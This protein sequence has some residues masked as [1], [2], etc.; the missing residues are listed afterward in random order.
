MPWVKTKQ[1]FNHYDG[2]F[3]HMNEN[4]PP[5]TAFEESF[6]AWQRVV[7]CLEQFA[8]C[9][10]AY[11]DSLR[12]TSDPTE[13]PRRMTDRLEPDISDFIPDLDREL[14]HVALVE[15]VKLDLD[16]RCQPPLGTADVSLGS[17]AIQIERLE[18]EQYLKR[19]PQLLTNGRPPADL[20]YEA[21]HVR[22]AT[23]DPLTIEQIKS[24]FP[25]QSEAL[26]RLLALEQG[27]QSTSL[28]K[29]R[30]PP[31]FNAGEQVDDFDLLTQLGSGAFATVY[32]A[33]Q[34]SL[35]RL[36]ALKISADQGNEP[37][38]LAQL[39]HPHI[40]RVY[41]QRICQDRG[42]RLLYMQY[43]S[44]GTLKAAIDFVRS[45]DRCQLDGASLVRAVDIQLDQ[46]GQSVPAESANR[47]F[48][49]QASWEQTICRL[50][51]QLAGALQYAHQQGVL[52]R[53]L[54]PANVLLTAEAG[55]QLVDFNISFCS[56]IDGA[57]PT[58]YFGGS[59][60]YMSPEQLAACDPAKG[61][62]PQSLGPS[63]D[64]FSLGV[65]LWETYFGQRPFADQNLQGSW[66][67]TL[68][69][70]IEQRKNGPVKIE[71]DRLVSP[72][73]RALHKVLL[74]CLAFDPQQRIQTGE[75]LQHELQ[76]CAQPGAKLILRPQGN[77]WIR[78]MQRHPLITLV[79]LAMVPNIGATLFNIYFNGQFVVPGLSS[80]EISA[81]TVQAKFTTIYQF[82][83]VIIYFLAF[84]FIVWRSLPL[85]RATKSPELFFATGSSPAE[86]DRLRRKSLKLGSFIATVC[87]VFWASA[88]FVYP[89]ALQLWG[90]PTWPRGYLHFVSAHVLSGMIAG[91]YPF[92]GISWFAIRG[93]YPQLSVQPGIDLKG[94]QAE[95]AELSRRSWFWMACAMLLPLFA[96][97]LMVVF[98]QASQVPLAIL[99][100][101]SFLGCL[102]FVWGTR[103]LQL[104]IWT[105]IG[106]FKGR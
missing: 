53:D 102:L 103:R 52:H 76:L 73:S 96:V 40:V 29:S 99:C 28:F 70:Q 45:M 11:L 89:A 85:L 5:N 19:F 36:V 75:R 54:K 78:C 79:L 81:E 37:Q 8:A 95:L 48:L 94:D 24:R 80:A 10:D 105:L 22:K 71:D 18:L 97:L 26:A 49:L 104:N 98:S 83:N 33:R 14:E 6:V 77:G 25:G 59:L 2:F 16:Y 21:F 65:V 55:P 82:A 101:G 62:S 64:L 100:L 30:R 13:T 46:Q 60:A 42:C 23:G 88:G 15:L 34:K 44:G 38:T 4:Q 47:E 63:S 3:R 61:V 17:P 93:I 67:Q 106:F 43:V 50:G 7:D 66:S 39:D 91:A 32:L 27:D 20:V 51:V 68:Q 90:V 31:E 84:Y 74:G 58:A 57:N 72:Q 9:W 12:G 92:L 86:V 35:Q 56:K 41:D 69:D 87:I 1:R